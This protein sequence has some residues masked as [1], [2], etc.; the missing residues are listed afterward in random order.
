MFEKKTNWPE[1]P[2]KLSDESKNSRIMFS[3]SYTLEK[4]GC[5]RPT[6]HDHTHA[7]YAFPGYKQSW[8]DSVFSCQQGFSFDIG[9]VGIPQRFIFIETRTTVIPLMSQVIYN[10]LILE[11]SYLW[12]VIKLNFFVFSS[13]YVLCTDPSKVSW[14]VLWTDSSPLV[15]ISENAC[16]GLKRKFL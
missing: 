3:K 9:Y 11:K 14:C 15:D 10:R 4:R 16:V 1:K 12:K 2:E 13:H 6:H 7:P 5:I 8:H